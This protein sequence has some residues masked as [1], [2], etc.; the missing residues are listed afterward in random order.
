M[1][2]R[3]WAE[4]TSDLPDDH[5]EDGDQVLQFGGKSVAMAIGEMLARCGCKVGEPIDAGENGWELH[6]EASGRRLWGQVTLVE[7]YIFV[8]QQ[9]SW[10]SKLFRSYHPAYVETLRRLGEELSADPRFHDVRW[11]DD[12]KVLSGNPGAPAPIED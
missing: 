9:N 2:V 10:F 5:L 12:G 4:F 8:F 6:V 7:G 11:F 3:P 1:K